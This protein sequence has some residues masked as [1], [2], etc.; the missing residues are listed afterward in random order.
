MDICLAYLQ[1]EMCLSNE[2]CCAVRSSSDCFPIGFGSSFYSNFKGC[3]VTS[4]QPLRRQPSASNSIVA[5]F[6]V[7][8]CVFTDASQSQAVSLLFYRIVYPLWHSFHMT[9]RTAAVHAPCHINVTWTK[10]LEESLSCLIFSFLT[11]F[12][13]SRRTPRRRNAIVNY[14]TR[15]RKL[16]T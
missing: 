11:P 5:L 12:G 16:F 9:Q 3:P 13:G 10:N 4:S 6:S 2:K 1:T 7:N 8:N 15:L 14:P